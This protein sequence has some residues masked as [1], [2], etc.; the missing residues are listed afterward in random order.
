MTSHDERMRMT[1]MYAIIIILSAMQSNLICHT[2]FSY[3]KTQQRVQPGFISLTT[4]L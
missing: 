1:L 3:L 2:L 4:L